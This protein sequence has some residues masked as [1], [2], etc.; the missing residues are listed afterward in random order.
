MN[1]GHQ[2]LFPSTF[3]LSFPHPIMFW[4]FQQVVTFEMY[5]NPLLQASAFP[6]LFCVGVFAAGNART[7]EVPRTS[8]MKGGQLSLWRRPGSWVLNW[9]SLLNQSIMLPLETSYLVFGVKYKGFWVAT[10]SF[11]SVSCSLSLPVKLIVENQ[12]SSKCDA[13]R[14]TQC[15]CGCVYKLRN[16]DTFIP[17]QFF[18]L[19]SRRGGLLISWLK[20]FLSFYGVLEGTASKCVAFCWT[21]SA[22]RAADFGK[23]LQTSG[24]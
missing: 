19:K 7:W 5:P 14:S 6:A 8:A 20:L 2:T 4:G 23:L 22:F 1:N 18:H 3:S 24:F 21:V 15:R 17:S 10:F 11:Q 9:A 16:I 13:I 12:V